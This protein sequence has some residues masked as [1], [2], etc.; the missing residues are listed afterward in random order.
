MTTEFSYAFN[1]SESVELEKRGCALSCCV[2]GR[3]RNAMK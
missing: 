3:I 1:T 2:K